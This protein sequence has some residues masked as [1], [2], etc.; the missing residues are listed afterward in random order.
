MAGRHWF[1]TRFGD[2]AIAGSS[3]PGD[4]VPPHTY[5]GIGMS[6]KSWPDHYG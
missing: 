5:S 3:I 2:Q 6:A 1:I 4:N